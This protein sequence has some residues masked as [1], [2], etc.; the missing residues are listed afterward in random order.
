MARLPQPGGD[1]GNWGDILN[2]Y[3][4]QSH[5][6]DGTIKDNSVG[7]AQIQS[8][9][10]TATTIADSS[11]TE[12]LLVPAVQTKLNAPA[13]IAD[14][15]VTNTKI[16][17]DTVSKSQLQSALRDELDAKLTKA[18]GDNTY[19]PVSLAD[20]VDTAVANAAAATAA[21]T[22][23]AVRNKNR[24]RNAVTS[25]GDSITALGGNQLGN[26]GANYYA[27]ACVRSGQ[28]IRW[29]HNGGIPSNNLAQMLARV[30]TD[31][32]AKNAGTCLIMAGTNNMGN[33]MGDPA[34]AGTP[35]YTMK[36]IVA[37]LQ[38]ANIRPV[39]CTIPPR[40]DNLALN[41]NV[42]AW[43][44]WL[45]FWGE[46]SGILVIDTYAA[47]VNPA[48]GAPAAGMIEADNVH[49]TAAANARM[50]EVVIGTLSADLRNSKPRLASSSADTSNLLGASGL[51]LADANA[52]GYGD[53]WIV[54]APITG[55]T[56]S[57]VDDI[58]IAGKWQRFSRA[59]GS[60]GDATIRREFFTGWA[61][62]NRLAF[63]MRVR[64]T[65]CVAGG[66]KWSVQIDQRGNT[67]SIKTTNPMYL[68]QQDIADGIL[69][70][71]FD[72]STD[73]NNIRLNLVSH[74]TGAGDVSFAQ[75]SL[76]NLTTL[77]V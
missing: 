54:P 28:R 3:L 45:T 29:V 60:V 40:N 12:A 32:V 4:A 56:P 22:A 10:V 41:A 36:Q 67:G 35:G 33:P 74:G 47:I 6:A 58:N 49:P 39:L 2:D 71:E 26:E 42:T 13:I 75:A 15:S 48:T 25:L 43:N 44:A 51:F 68:W 66:H 8:N 27:Q 57:L 63:A 20:E 18:V 9:S 61:V 31:V 69:Y 53:T 50:A 17:A 55:L 34:V 16:A 1:N 72:V 21:A 46:R 73:V 30:Q 24:D 77:K 52:D 76:W 5:K 11:I 65:G 19:A 37:E 59:T 23:L 38:A 70:Y 14:G 62:G 7:T 64:S